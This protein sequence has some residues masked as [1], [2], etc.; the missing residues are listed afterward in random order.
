LRPAVHP[1]A[2]LIG[3]LL[4]SVTWLVL[5]EPPPPAAPKVTAFGTARPA[6]RPRVE[7]KTVELDP[8]I[9]RR[10]VGS[11][12][13]DVGMDVALDLDGGK[14]FAAGTGAPR[15]ELLAT[16]E[17]EFYI[18]ELDADLAFDIEGAGH[19]VGFSVR[20]PTGTLAAKRTR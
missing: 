10:Y 18:P 1:L 9:L 15:Y 20:L 4:L 14:L 8:E 19:A 2:F 11:Y 12:R 16:S 3:S 7:R 5:R 13:L 6:A 17:T